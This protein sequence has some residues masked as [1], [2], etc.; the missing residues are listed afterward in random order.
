M[1]ARSARQPNMTAL[2]HHVPVGQRGI[3]PARP[4]RLAILGV[5]RRHLGRVRQQFRQA[6]AVCPDMRDYKDAAGEVAREAAS[7]VKN[8]REGSRRT[9]D[10]N[11]V[12]ARLLFPVWRKAGGPG[13]VFLVVHSAQPRSV[14]RLASQ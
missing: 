1:L 5:R 10:H 11:D 4:D 2:D 6:A 7:D 12:P 14:P 13:C 9:A 3:D 8:G